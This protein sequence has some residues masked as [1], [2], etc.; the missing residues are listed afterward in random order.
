VLLSETFLSQL[1]TLALTQR[2]RAHG[3]LKGMHRSPRVG[4]GM[5][6]A[7]FRPYAE[8]DDIRNIDWGIYLR[9][10]R[11][12]LRLF[13]EEADVPIYILLDASQS[14]DHGHP[15]KLEY[16]RGLAAALSYVALL[17]HDR[18]NLAAF[19][20]T[21]RETLPTRRGKNQAPQVFRFLEQVTPSGRTSLQ[22]ALRRYFSAPRTRGLVVLISDF[23]DRDG[24]EGAFAILR[25]FRHEV[26]LLQVISP[27]E[28]DPQLPEEV[29]LVDA[30][31]GTASEIE[32][33]PGLL[34]AYRETF[35]RHV[36][37]IEA[38]CRKYGWGY[39]RVQTEIPLEDQVLR[40][41]REAGLLR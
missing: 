39:A 28:R 33:T 34:T 21:V 20:D 38:W 9:M 40:G 25:R 14:M 6:F 11:L 41:F 37:E 15:G 32:I 24:V 5:V 30:E 13:E 19:T 23:L 36:R 12:V 1:E 29:V 3:Q 18:V 2:Q 17:N 8:G 27:Q 31:E 26:M 22:G 7:D 35:D 10:D 16:G 4:A